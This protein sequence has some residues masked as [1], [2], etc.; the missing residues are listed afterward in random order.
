MK[1]T[2]PGQKLGLKNCL[3]VFSE[4]SLLSSI[5]AGHIETVYY[6]GLSETRFPLAQLFEDLF[7]S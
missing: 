3:V 7:A 5:L 4:A 1:A 6:K 2:I